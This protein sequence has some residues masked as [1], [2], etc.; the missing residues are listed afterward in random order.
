[1]SEAAGSKVEED[2]EGLRFRFG[3]R[4]FV[5]EEAC[6]GAGLENELEKLKA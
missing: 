4:G 3:G 2:E 6:K 1:M 5:C